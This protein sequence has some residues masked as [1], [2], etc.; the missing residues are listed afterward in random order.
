MTP[1]LDVEG[2]K[3]NYGSLKLLKVSAL[4]LTGVRFLV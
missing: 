1:V 3:K 4:K 2:L